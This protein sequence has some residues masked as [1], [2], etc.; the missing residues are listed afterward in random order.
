M[1]GRNAE[2]VVV[3]TFRVI[4]PGR[5]GLS[6]AAA[7]EAVGYRCEGV[8]G[9]HDPLRRR[10]PRRRPPGRRHPGRHRGRGGLAGRAGG[11]HRRRAPVRDRSGSRPWPRI[12]VGDRCTRWCRCP[13]PAVGAARLRSGVTFAVAGD[14]IAATAGRGPRRPSRRGRR[15]P[16]GHATTRPPPSPPT[17]SSPCSARSSG[18]RPPPVC[19]STPLP[20][21]CGR[22]PTTP[23][24]SGR[25]RR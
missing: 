11:H 12:R 5:A 17:T 23:S 25:G 8:L 22:R 15:R 18:W 20:A 7:L 1:A 10:R 3:T 19:R 21:W 9:R 16:A 24:P 2:R 14:P 13:S 4:G 6:I